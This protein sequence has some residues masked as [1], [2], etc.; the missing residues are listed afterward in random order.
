MWKR[1]GFVAE[2]LR[3]GGETFFERLN[4]FVALALHVV[5]PAWANA[6]A[7]SPCRLSA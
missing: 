3:F 5:L 2:A 7:T 1:L 6:T 4:L